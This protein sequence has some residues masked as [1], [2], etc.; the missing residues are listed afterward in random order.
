MFLDI[1]DH[2]EIFYTHRDHSVGENKSYKIGEM[3]W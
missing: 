1:F 2:I 3:D